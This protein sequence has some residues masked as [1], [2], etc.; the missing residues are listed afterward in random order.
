VGGRKRVG[1]EREKIGTG[2]APGPDSL[3]IYVKKKRTRLHLKG[4][5]LGEGRMRKAI[6]GRTD[7]LSKVET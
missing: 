7:A 5:G 4:N 2:Q 3:E 1:K 6:L